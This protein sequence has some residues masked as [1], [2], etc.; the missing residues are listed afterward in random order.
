MFSGGTCKSTE[1]RFVLCR[2][3][4][5][6]DVLVQVRRERICKS[7]CHGRVRGVMNVR[8]EVCSKQVVRTRDRKLEV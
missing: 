7:P 5:E 3:I 2:R 8:S 4:D 6:R 1:G